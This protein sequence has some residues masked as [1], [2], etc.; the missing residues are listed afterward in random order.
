MLHVNF[1][2]SNH[3]ELHIS[4]EITKLLARKTCDRIPHLP[5]LMIAAELIDS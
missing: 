5:E 1:P 3:A 2:T 4:K